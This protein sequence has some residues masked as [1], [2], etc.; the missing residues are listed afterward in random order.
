MAAL[1]EHRAED[2]AGAQRPRDEETAQPR[3]ARAPPQ[4]SSETPPLHETLNVSIP[5]SICKYADRRILKGMGNRAHAIM[6]SGQ[7]RRDVHV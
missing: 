3:M 6:E 7:A 4:K 5:L 1:L 2:A